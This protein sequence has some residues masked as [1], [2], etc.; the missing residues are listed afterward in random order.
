MPNPTIVSAALNDKELRDSITKL[1]EDYKNSLNDMKTATTD[2]VGEIQEIIKSIGSTKVDFSGTLESLEKAK[3]KMTAAASGGGGTS[4]PPKDKYA[5]NTIGALEESIR[6]EEKKRKEMKLGSKELRDQNQLIDDQKKKL[7]RE[8]E[9]LSTTLQKLYKTRIGNAISLPSRTLSDAET[10]L[11]E[12][13]T[14]MSKIRG[15]GFISTQQINRVQN[16]IDN[17]KNK[18]ER[19]RSKKP[20]TMQEVLGMDENSIEAIARKMQALKR[21]TIDPSNAA[22]V[23]QLGEEYT[24]LGKKQN[25]YLGKNLLIQKSN[26]ML[27]ST[28][29]Y[30]R[31]RIIY[32]FT[33]GALAGFFRDLRNIRAEYEMLDRSLGILVGDFE[34]GTRIF[35]ELNEMALKSPFTLIELGTAAKQLTAYNFAADEVVDTTRRIA[36]ISAALGVPIE[37]LV[38]NLGQIKAQG[39]LT[40]RDA[41]D[42]ANAG[43]AIVPMLADMYTKQKAFGKELTTTADVY[44]MM[45]KKMVSYG[46]VLSVIQKVTDEGGKF[47]NFQARQADT[48]K[49]QIANLSL[50]Y[51]N[52]M[53]DIGASNQGLL[54]GS[55]QIVRSLFQNWKTVINV[56]EQLIVTF[57]TYKVVATATTLLT[58]RM[59]VGGI[60]VNLRNYIR[61]IK[62]ATGAMA[63]FNAVTKMNPIAFF[64]TALATVVGYFLIF[65]DNVEEAS[66]EVELFGE[67][68][69]KTLKKIDT[70][71]KILDGTSE[72]S[73]TYKKTLTEL[74]GIMHEYGV[75]LDAEKARRDEV[76][77][78]TEQTIQLIKEESSE[79]QRANQ[80]EKARETFD[81]ENEAARK[82]LVE[83]IQKSS[84]IAGGGVSAEYIK[85]V[86]ENAEAVS[87]IIEEVVNSNLNYILNKQGDE[88]NAGVERIYTIVN[89]RLT[90]IGIKGGEIQQILGGFLTTT[91]AVEKF[92]KATA[93]AN[94]KL[95]RRTQIINRNHEIAQ[96]SIQST[97]TFTQKVEA[98]SRALQNNTNDALSLYNKIYDIVKIA[99]QNHTINFDLK[100]TA[101]NPPAWMLDKSLPELQRLAQRFAAI[102]ESG[103][104]VEGYNREGTYEQALRYA[105][106]ARKKQE[107][108]ERA[109]RTKNNTKT[110]KEKDAILDAIKEEISLTKKL[111][112][113]YDKLTSKGASHADAI[114][115]VQDRYANTI[116]LLDIDLGKFGL[117]KFDTNIIT[118]KDPNKQ[119]E[120]FKNLRDILESKGLLNLERSKVVDA[121]IQ[122]L[123]VSA[124]TFNLDK[125]TKGLNNELDRLKEEYELAVS[126]DADPELGS[127]FTDWMGIDMSDLPRTASEYAKRYTDTL[128][129]KLKEYNANIELPNL[130]NI[131]DDDLRELQNRVGIGNITQTYVDEITKGVKAVRDVFRKEKE[132]TSRD[133]NALIEKYGGLQAKLLKIYK[134]NVQQQA[135]IVREFGTND[136]QIKAL[137]L[138][139]K[140]KISQDPA[141]IARLQDELAK[142]MNDVTSRNPVALKTYQAV[143]NEQE[144]QTGKAYWEDF[145]DSDLYSM[146]FTDMANNSTQAIQMIIDKLNELKDKVKED[147]ASMKALIK[148]LEDAEDELMS[149]DPFAGIANSIKDWTNA[150]KEQKDAQE[151]L[152]QANIEVAGSETALKNAQSVGDKEEIAEAEQK[153]AQAQQ[154]QATAQTKVVQSGN[155]AKK[156][157]EQLKKSFQNLS[158][159]LG[160]VSGLLGSVAQIFRAVGD[161]DTADAIDAINQGFTI[162]TTVISAVTAALIILQSSNPWLLAMAAALS[163]IVGLVSFLSG[164]SNKKITEQVEASERAVKRLELAYID[165]QQAVDR[166]YGTATIGA[167]QATLANKELQLAEIQRQIQLEKSRTGKNRDEDKII[168]L[169]KQYKELFYEIKNGY[170]EIVDD[171]MGTDVASFAENLVSSMIDAFKQ[172]E[173]YMKVFSDKFDEMV[174]N[175]IMKSIVSRVVSQYLDAIWND[176]DKK[177][178]ER[179]KDESDDLA[180]LQNR[181]TEVRQMSDDE[182]RRE[183][184]FANGR[185]YDALS[186]AYKDTISQAQVD[187]YR[188]IA[189]DELSAAQRRFDAASAFTGSDV[190]YVM[191]RITEVMPELG[192]KLQNILGEYYKF[193]ESSET[194]LSALQQGIRGVTEDTAGAIEGYM[195][196]VSQQVYYQSDILTQIRD[197]L[198]GGDGDVQ[199]GVQAQ[200]LLQLQQSYQ[201]QMSI[202]GILEGVLTPSGQGFRVEL[203]S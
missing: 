182:I 159:E 11:R 126:L 34:R 72:T 42:F 74:S 38:Y 20:M 15:K 180:K 45:S 178:N 97:M 92:A 71:K 145:K 33:L 184:A 25:E 108:E 167:K 116:K 30:I 81:T 28:F 168:D 176:L 143:R 16:A 48:L 68:A 8:T 85:A 64:A 152:K 141:E 181:A 5:D 190:D 102:A 191:E 101:D 90:K 192:E 107:D 83:T 109:A 117:P 202:Q 155:K 12:L 35:N 32:A 7:K 84:N 169:Q 137:D 76:N 188:K 125:I 89:E 157:Q 47:F 142:T 140:I 104:H 138:I 133:W 194:Q 114:K 86:R 124:K 14:I 49:V 67:N 128:N 59:F 196:G 199:L 179:S 51:N 165:L 171:L 54:S 75:E 120:Y 6:L 175:M 163:V 63:T 132:D 166:A 96:E 129:K 127:I 26:N 78:A 134:D 98:N 57:G 40:A 29:G 177:I 112:G 19:L 44:D 60:L 69:S 187:Q 4:A 62:A 18:I 111:Q 189:E 46:D 41:R 183:I 56:I 17:V 61:G 13:E 172:G 10:K 198:I 136:E 135:S 158:N 88:L 55:I 53:N 66:Q 122:E 131:T 93:D 58:S 200:M 186:G 162:M 39:S 95:E 100:L 174:D 82:N 79:R 1:V 3:K 154:K 113:E 147:P 94:E 121:V 149:R 52:M 203:L 43:L 130:L 37:R 2:T 36:D 23:K 156:A 153:L 87:A 144:S 173:D 91:T 77:K 193:G 164:N 103:G 99:Q 106:A 24:R 151:E 123:D 73:S 31:N 115:D 197:I 80:L 139:S 160:N 22:Q 150:T 9:S 110:K 185:R 118:G 195:N 170:T 105:S 65:K 70:F 148:S 161:D 201:V 50:A 119:L 146:T 21:V 27:A